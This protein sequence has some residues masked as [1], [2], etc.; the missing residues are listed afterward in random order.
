MTN[1]TAQTHWLTGEVLTWCDRD[2]S[3]S[4]GLSKYFYSVCHVIVHCLFAIL[5]WL[6]SLSSLFH[7][8]K[9]GLADSC[10]VRTYMKQGRQYI[11]PACAGFRFLTYNMFI[12]WAWIAVSFRMGMSACFQ[13]VLGDDS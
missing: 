13:A 12:L 2:A 3:L 5:F 11:D 6:R 7:R 10:D 8:F 9:A 4:P 1:C